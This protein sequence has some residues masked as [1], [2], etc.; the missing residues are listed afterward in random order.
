[1][2][3]EMAIYLRARQAINLD[4]HPPLLGKGVR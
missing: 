4:V 1:M 3:G 2:S